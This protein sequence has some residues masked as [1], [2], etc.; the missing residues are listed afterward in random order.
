ML[1]Q[2]KFQ[3]LSLIDNFNMEHLT[4]RWVLARALSCAHS[5]WNVCVLLLN[6]LVVRFHWHYACNFRTR[7]FAIYCRVVDTKPG[8][9][10]AVGVNSLS[11][12]W[13][14][15]CCWL[16]SA[17]S[18]HVVMFAVI[19]RLT[20]VSSLTLPISGHLNNAIARRT[21]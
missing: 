11:T 12:R 16:N 14:L 17:D 2:L 7:N 6:S 19:F 1:Q 13:P 9:L 4:F 10:W 3:H 15:G 20:S 5:L 18:A 8:V 21:F